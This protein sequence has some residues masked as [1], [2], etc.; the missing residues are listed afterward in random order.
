MVKKTGDK[1]NTILSHLHV[2]PKKAKL[3][4]TK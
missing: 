3:I 4:E 1:T 2:E